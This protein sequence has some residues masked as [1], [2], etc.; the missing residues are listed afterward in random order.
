MRTIDLVKKIFLGAFFILAA[1]ALSAVSAPVRA[2]TAPAALSGIVVNWSTNTYVP[3]GFHGKRLPTSG[4]DVKAWLTVFSAGKPVSVSNYFVYWYADDQLLQ[5]GNGLASISFKAPKTTSQ[6]VNLQARAQSPGG[7]LLVGS[8]QVPVINPVVAIQS[9]YPGGVFTSPTAEVAALP[10]FF[11]VS[12]PLSLVFRW[13]ANGVSAAS[14]ENPAAASINLGG[15]AQSGTKVRVQVNVAN[16][17]DGTSAN[18][19]SN[20]TYQKL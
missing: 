15:S 9:G 19:Y 18:A 10:Y 12:G 3:P 16:P 11:N 13:S 6:I 1:I 20:F 14:G 17:N 2:Q 8:I 7:N 5:S 4:S